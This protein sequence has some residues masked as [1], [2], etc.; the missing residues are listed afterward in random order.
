VT[1]QP[2]RTVVR[3]VVPGTTCE[4]RVVHTALTRRYLVMSTGDSRH[5]IRSYDSIPLSTE[6]AARLYANSIWRDAIRTR[7]A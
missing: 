7:N 4:I 2:F 5:G 3:H 1:G 6:A